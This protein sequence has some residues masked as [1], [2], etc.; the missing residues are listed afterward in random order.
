MD[1]VWS[2]DDL[3]KRYGLAPEEITFIESSIKGIEAD[4]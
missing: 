3:Y 1:R 4:G 2:D